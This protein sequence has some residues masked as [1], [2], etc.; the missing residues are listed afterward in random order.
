MVIQL[1][2]K[3][4]SMTFL[5]VNTPTRELVVAWS[6][7]WRKL[8]LRELKNVQ[9][10]VSQCMIGTV[11]NK[12]LQKFQ[13]GG[14]Y[15]MKWP[16]YSELANELPMNKFNPDGS[17]AV[18]F[19]AYS[20]TTLPREKLSKDR[21]RRLSLKAAIAVLTDKK[22][23]S[24]PFLSKEDATLIWEAYF[25]RWPI[26]GG[27]LP[28]VT[29]PAALPQP[30]VAE[31]EIIRPRILLPSVTATAVEASVT[32]PSPEG[33]RVVSKV[34]AFPPRI[35]FFPAYSKMVH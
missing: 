17:K 23:S 32:K 22:R 1:K 4:P 24:G 35:G 14:L 18:D 19:R 26:S 27:S 3:G 20:Q 8:S 6:H 28:P 21:G 7:P 34:V 29:A 10:K 13:F 12:E 5:Y 2:R 33:H 11:I 25:E 15:Q 16:I 31:A 30:E 9:V